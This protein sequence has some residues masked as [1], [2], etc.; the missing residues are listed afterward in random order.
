MSLAL[1]RVIDRNIHAT[2]AFAKQSPVIGVNIEVDNVQAA[3]RLVNYAKCG[4][5]K[6]GR[7]TKNGS[8]GTAVRKDSQI[9][10][11]RIGEYGLECYRYP[12]V[13]ICVQLAT[14]KAATV[15]NGAPVTESDILDEIQIACPI[16]SRW[17]DFLKTGIDL[18]RKVPRSDNPPGGFPGPRQAGA[19]NPVNSHLSEHLSHGIGL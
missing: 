11:T 18:Y 14:E 10:P 7:P 6:P 1:G 15:V 12:C 17:S 19:N 8:I 9:L 3:G 2:N 5:P 16:A 4:Q 13:K